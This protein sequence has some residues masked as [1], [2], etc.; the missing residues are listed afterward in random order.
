MTRNIDEEA[1]R[2]SIG[3]GLPDS[4]HIPIAAR[5]VDA[6][7]RFVGLPTV[8]SRQKGT[9]AALLVQLYKRPNRDPTLPIWELRKSAVLDA[10]EQV[11]VHVEFKGY[12]RAYQ[13]AFPTE[14]LSGLVLDHVMNRRIAQL[15]GFT[16]VRILPVSKGANSSS[17]R[18]SEQLGGAYHSSSEMVRRNKNLATFIEHADLADLVKMLD[19]KTGGGFLD[20]VNEAQRLVGGPVLSERKTDVE[21]A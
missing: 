9:E 7:R 2:R 19:I 17:G 21:P 16:Y 20:P 14:Q 8:L 5:D 10:V 11:W 4:L 6:I 15:K 3:Q 18:R 1:R 13:Q 12:R